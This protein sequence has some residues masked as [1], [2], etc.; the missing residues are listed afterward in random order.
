MS[1]TFSR[2]TIKAAG[3]M[4]I[5]DNSVLLL[6][7]PD[8]SW[9]FP[10]GKIEGGETPI[11]AACR[12]SME[13]VGYKPPIDMLWQIDFSNNGKVQFTTFCAMCGFEVILNTD[14]H[15]E[16][17]WF[18]FGELPDN[19]HPNAKQTI[20]KYTRSH[21]GIGLDSARETDHNGWI[22]V[23][24]NPITK[25]GIFEYLGRQVDG[26]F[27]PDQ[28][29]RVLRSPEELSKRETIE[30]FRLTPWIDEHVM[31]G[32]PESGMVSAEEKGIEGVIGE[33]TY[34]DDAAQMIRGNI[35]VFSSNMD[36]LI[37]RGKRELSAGYRCKYEVCS[38]VWNG[39]KYDAI[40]KDIRANH[41]ALVKEGRMG[42]D[43]A[44]LDHQL[45]K[46]TFDA[47]DI[48]MADEK[49]KEQMDA[50]TKMVGD[51]LKAMDEK[52]DDLKKEVK[53]SK[54]TDNDDDVDPKVA[55]DKAAKDAAEEKEKEEKEGK[56]M[57]ARIKS[58]M[59]AAVKPL[60]DQI[61]G[62]QAD[63]SLQERDALASK[64]SN[65]GVAVDSASTLSLADLQA[66]AVETL[67]LKAAKGSERVALDSYFHNRTAPGNE[68][69]F[70]L[71]TAGAS[72]SNSKAFDEHMQAA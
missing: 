21:L 41:L 36:D 59:D 34:W 67:G 33:Q 39:E 5:E 13:E 12:E 3:I 48:T 46:F 28:I 43:V 2:A 60:L 72:G 29:V 54:A 65:Y 47:R 50:L 38:G 71:D 44:V 18:A 9:A 11:D 22:E 56:A 24:G 64:L 8:G 20:E 15:S 61:T 31:L 52:I 30:S 10:G 66:K 57:D 42:P 16:Y 51:G 49:L 62:L 17:E 58:A 53:D 40:Q 32:H 14:E 69:G 55:A 63:K 26:S 23:K 6:K 27:E 25:A 19:I 35:K 37:A 68:V 4:Y 1:D 45:I 7:R 70:A